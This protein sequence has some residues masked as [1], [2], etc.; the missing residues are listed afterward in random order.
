MSVELIYV[1]MYK[2]ML[3]CI[4]FCMYWPERILYYW[5]IFNSTKYLVDFNYILYS[6]SMLHTIYEHY[7]IKK[8]K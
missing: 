8:I 7:L 2:T 5:I 1:D 3:S 4:V 6:C